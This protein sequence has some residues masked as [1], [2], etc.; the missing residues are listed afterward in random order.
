MPTQSVGYNN[1]SSYTGTVGN[2]VYQ[3]S[4]AMPTGRT[5]RDGGAPIRVTSV[6]AGYSSIS[7]YW[8][9]VYRGVE[10]GGAYLF[11]ESGSTFQIR[12]YVNAG[13]NM[14]FGRNTGVSGT[15]YDNADGQPYSAGALSYSLDYQFVPTAPVSASVSVSGRSATV[16]G[17]TSSDAGG[18]T[19]S[20]YRVQYRTSTNNSTWGSW[21]NEQ[22]LSGGTYTYTNL[23]PALYYQFRVYAVNEVGNSVAT[24]PASSVFIS[25]GGKRWSGSAWVATATAK[26]WNG[27]AWVD[28]TVAKRWNGSSWVDL[29]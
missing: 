29:S 19:I 11:S 27:S 14:Y 22:T 10:T 2:F 6:Y 18:G 9:I 24:S 17:G 16:T 20:S 1:T 23:T 25:G 8:R 12:Q 4:V 13:G 21:G 28:L 26:R 3:D 15:V 7:A 5:N